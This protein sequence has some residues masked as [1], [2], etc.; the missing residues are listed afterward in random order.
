[1]PQLL[2]ERLLILQLQVPLKIEVGVTEQR[3]VVA[4]EYI[5][6]VN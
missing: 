5:V 4:L 3:E 1:M 2:A 6:Q